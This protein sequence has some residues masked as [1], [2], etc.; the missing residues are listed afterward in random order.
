M[1]TAIQL[2]LNVFPIIAN[3]ADN[4]TF[5]NWWSS[6]VAGALLLKPKAKNAC[7]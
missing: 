5:S 6:E 1:I 3:P 2:G 4:S 7:F